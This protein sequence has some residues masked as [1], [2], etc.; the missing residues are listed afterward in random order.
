MQQS[1]K[2]AALRL[3]PDELKGLEAKVQ[4]IE[5]NREGHVGW[6]RNPSRT[7][8]DSLEIACDYAGDT[9]IL[10]PDFL[11]FSEGDDAAIVAD[12]VDPHGDYLADRAS[13]LR[14]LADYVEKHGS[15]FGRIEAV[16]ELD[17]S[18]LVLDLKAQNVRDMVR[19]VANSK[20]PIAVR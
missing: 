6:Y 4:S 3:L 17:G 9:L 16:A 5:I 18:V 13:K 8:Q 19:G 11:F 1:C 14:G 15:N 2:S 12:I 10:R 20:E 7:S